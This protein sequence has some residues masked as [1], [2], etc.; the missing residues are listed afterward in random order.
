MI[1]VL[2]SIALVGLVLV[3]AACSGSAVSGSPSTSAPPST[4]PSTT[5]S[6][7]VSPT[8]APVGAI[9][10]A[11][12]ATD[13]VLRFEQGG[14]FVAPAFLASQAP[15]FTLYGDGT[16]IFRNPALEG[17]A[18][19]GDIYRSGPFRIA[20]LNEE[21]IQG[22]LA[23]ALGEG[24]LGA[25]RPNY[26]NDRVADAPTATFTVNAGG[27]RKTVSVYA[28]GIDMDG[29]TDALPR[30]AFLKLAERLGN[31][32][33]NGTIA[34]AVYAPERYR[35]ILLDGF[36]GAPGAK[37]WPWKD[38]APS[39]FV[40][41]VD[42]NSFQLPASVLTVA[43][44][45]ALGIDRYQGGMQGATLIGPDGKAYSF[46]LRPLLPDDAR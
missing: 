27:L 2:R 16:I 21:Q 10:H 39:D 18:P 7:I 25:A 31:F 8:P 3:V 14:G 41:P 17:P 23:M 46:S 34:T 19:V 26:S 4:T 15:I 42:P 24:G 28:L 44:V 22:T 6:I 35:G 36:G 13:V 9:D 30:A 40:A 5:P 20:R 45:Q 38:I 12:G 37:P 33:Q 1:V 43:Q 32:D 11:T 29:L